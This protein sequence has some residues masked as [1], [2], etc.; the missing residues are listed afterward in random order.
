[1]S[2]SLDTLSLLKVLTPAA[3][4]AP[5]DARKPCD[6]SPRSKIANDCDSVA[7]ILPGKN[8]PIA[9]WGGQATALAKLKYNWP[10]LGLF[11]RLFGLVVE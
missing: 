6:F 7:V 11:T 9:V 3:M 4:S 5:S 8:V 1:M 2:V 10:L